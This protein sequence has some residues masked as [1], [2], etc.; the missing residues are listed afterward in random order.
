[1]K[2]QGTSHKYTKHIS[3]DNEEKYQPFFGLKKTN[4][5]LVQ[6]KFNDGWIH[7]K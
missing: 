4:P 6:V 1:M 7:E 2:Q 5:Y 3:L